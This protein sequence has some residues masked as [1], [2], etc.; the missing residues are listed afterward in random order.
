MN[1]DIKNTVIALVVIAF[2]DFGQL[3]ECKAKGGVY[4][5]DKCLKKD[6]LLE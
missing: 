1:Q 6:V 3:K 5:S 2:V 4:V